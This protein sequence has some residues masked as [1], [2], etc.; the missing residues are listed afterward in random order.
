MIRRVLLSA[1]TSVMVFCI[2]QSAIALEKKGI[3]KFKMTNDKLPVPEGF[4]RVTDKS[5]YSEKDGFGWT[6]G[7][8]VAWKKLMSGYYWAPNVIMTG[9]FPD[10]ITGSWVAPGQIISENSSHASFDFK[11]EIEFKID[12]PA[13]NYFV[14]VMLGDYYY[15][16]GYFD[17][18]KT[19]Y[20]VSING[21]KE[22]ESKLTDKEA[23]DIFY[24]HEFEDYNPQ[25][26]YWER[27]VKPRFE[28]T[29]HLIKASSDGSIRI[30]VKDMPV[31]M[32]AIWPEADKAQGEVWIKQL[33]KLREAS[34][35]CRL[36]EYEKEKLQKAFFSPSP[37][38]ENKGFVVFANDNWMN[39]IYPYTRP[40]QKA[41]SS[42]IKLFAAPGEIEPV[43]FGIYPLRDIPNLKIEVSDLKDTQQNIIPSANVD[44]R[45]VKYLEFP[46]LST[47]EFYMIKGATE[48]GYI[49]KPWILS[50]KNSMT[51]YKNITR[52]CW[53]RIT[54]PENA[55]P[56]IY[57]GNVT[58]SSSS[59]KTETRKIML[60][61]LSFR[62]KSFSELDKYVDLTISPVYPP[63]PKMFP[64]LNK[65]KAVLVKDW[66]SY[67][68]NVAPLSY[69]A[70]EQ[71]WLARNIE[72][73]RSKTDFKALEECVNDWKNAGQ[74]KAFF[75]T[76]FLRKTAA[77][78]MGK[79]LPSYRPANEVKEFP[80]DFDDVYIE[81]ARLIDN[82]F[83]K[84]RWP[85]IIF[86]EGGEGGGYVE[87]RYFELYVH[88]L[89]HKAGIKNKL[90]LSGTFDYF[91]E[92]V[93][94]VWSPDDYYFNLEHYDWMKKNNVN[95][96]YLAGFNRFERGLYFW[97]IGAKGHHNEGYIAFGG[98]P[99][100][101]FDSP[102]SDYGIVY[103]S[104]F[105]SGINPSIPSE[106]VRE[107]HDDAR[108]LFQLQ[109]LIKE[110][111]G[112]NNESVMKAVVSA[113]RLMGKLK[114][115]INPDLEQARKMGYP[116]N[117]VYE[118]IRWSVA[119]EIEKLGKTLAE[120][121][122]NG[123]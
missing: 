1:V 110:A 61:V 75:I 123:K 43:T 71:Y 103:P 90:A 119:K 86:D 11:G 6:G 122:T 70:L 35:E 72:D 109:E 33:D 92:I 38:Q 54:V 18:L 94:L 68:F 87:G 95:I 51:L 26:A 99:Y 106:Y 85:D 8:R 53:L 116:S 111:E 59:G 40:E 58:V 3:I 64:G 81:L 91:K 47:G 50:G 57:E 67:G 101:F 34:C 45:V 52:E 74:I 27:Y 77:H 63:H 19:S 17:Y 113:G 24:N 88:N 104:R 5:D 48:L 105:G 84:E 28:R 80:K 97:R 10:I 114:K 25:I 60:K 66:L 121:R 7:K 78:F 39:E 69:S 89:L 82:K 56:G 12:L 22:V 83:K 20:S 30:K 107:G 41:I 96:F 118:K 49:V 31:D 44:V 76:N 32:I 15:K 4:I 13:G 79:T 65:G 14:Y 117:D 21:K 108:Y 115:T 100:N 23:E 16:H 37:E 73:A 46:E 29:T 55:K 9:T 36:K 62:L 98:E 2:S 112:N 102:W 42:D 120:S 93:P